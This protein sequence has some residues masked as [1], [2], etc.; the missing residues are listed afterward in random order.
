MSCSFEVTCDAAGSF[1]WCSGELWCAEAEPV[2]VWINLE[3]CLICSSQM[4]LCI[5]TKPGSA[6]E[7]GVKKQLCLLC[8]CLYVFAAV[9]EVILIYVYIIFDIWYQFLNLW[10]GHWRY[11]G[12]HL[13]VDIFISS[14]ERSCCF[15]SMVALILRWFSLI[16]WHL[17]SWSCLLI[18][19]PCVI[20]IAV[21]ACHWER[22]HLESVNHALKV[23]WPSVKRKP[24]LT[25]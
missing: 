18:H 7:L 1:S 8:T 9:L 12:S 17:Q 13:I 4:G 14:K 21:C 10:L 5:Y 3:R 24:Q 19:I 25:Y 11:G 20:H 22:V 15:C 16:F 23:S 2:S 6:R